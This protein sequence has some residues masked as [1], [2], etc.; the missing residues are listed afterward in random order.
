MI[1]PE[2]IV[3]INIEIP[4]KC[5]HKTDSI[6]AVYL[7]K[8]ALYLTYIASQL[9]TESFFTYHDGNI[10]KPVLKFK[11]NKH[12][13]FHVHTSV[14]KNLFKNS[15]FNPLK[16]NI[17]SSWLLGEEDKYPTETPFYNSC[18]LQDLTL[19]ENEK[20]RFE[21]LKDLNNVQDGLKLLQVWLKQRELSYGYGAF[22][23]ELMAMFVVYLVKSKK[24]NNA[25]SSYQVIRNVWIN[26]GKL[27][28]GFRTK[29]AQIV[30]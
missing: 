8:R 25:M 22:T 9:E 20:V 29:T 26:L 3:D 5:F 19:D 12:V 16:S 15:K 4:I 17:R 18:V 10:L 2:I 7:Q 13:S 30:V 11:L 6:N 1:K 14:E 27:T 28:F 23:P 24:I 21:V